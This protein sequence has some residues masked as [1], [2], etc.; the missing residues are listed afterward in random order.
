MLLSDLVLNFYVIL[1]LNFD[2]FP[3]A[4]RKGEDWLV[5]VS[6]WARESHVN[7]VNSR[8]WVHKL[9]FLVII[10]GVLLGPHF[11]YSQINM[12]HNV[13]CLPFPFIKESRHFS[14]QE[15]EM[16]Q[17][18]CLGLTELNRDTFRL[19]HQTKEHWRTSVIMT[20]VLVTDCN[21]SISIPAEL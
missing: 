2:F 10:D 14:N 17:I 9:V 21:L 3:L 7:T 15:M 13:S 12:A 8:N 6:S 11:I 18:L 1:Q 4:A 16:H 20:E 5:F 19:R